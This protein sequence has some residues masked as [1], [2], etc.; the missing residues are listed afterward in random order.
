MLICL[1][2]LI[3]LWLLYLGRFIAL[4]DLLIHHLGVVLW[5]HTGCQ[6]GVSGGIDVGWRR[7]FLNSAPVLLCGWHQKW[8][9]LELT[10]M[11]W[12]LLL[13]CKRRGRSHYLP[14][15][16]GVAW[17]RL[18]NSVII[19]PSC[20]HIGWVHLVRRANVLW[21]L[22]YRHIVVIILH[23]LSGRT[24]RVLMLAVS[25]LKRAWISSVDVK[26]II[27]VVFHIKVL[28]GSL[29]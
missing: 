10:E 3:L 27:V 22:G 4:H 24:G 12:W 23:H 16:N 18:T 21:C 13:N 1:L 25:I 26:T 2:D 19:H 11:L 28:G 14:S 6:S 9:G 5:D 8:L 20:D 29:R 17:K 15:L 7:L